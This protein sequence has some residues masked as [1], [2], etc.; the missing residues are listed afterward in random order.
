MLES[1]YC[2]NLNSVCCGL[3]WVHV[4][5]GSDMSVAKVVVHTM[6]AVDESKITNYKII[7]TKCERVHYGL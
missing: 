6:H 1:K 3:Q 7:V 4:T 2:C 5:V